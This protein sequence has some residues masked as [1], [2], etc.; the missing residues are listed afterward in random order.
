MAIEYKIEIVL[1]N[2]MIND[3][4]YRFKKNVFFDKIDDFSN[5][6]VFEFRLANNT[7]TMPNF[8]ITLYN[9]GIYICKYDCS[10]LWLNIEEIETYLYEKSKNIFIL[11]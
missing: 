2:Q 1:T 3:L 9:Y 4:I 6:E 10:Q 7:G 11:E 8:T 5:Q